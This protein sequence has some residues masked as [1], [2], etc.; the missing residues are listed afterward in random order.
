MLVR[1]YK[2]QRAFI[3]KEAKRMQVSQAQVV[4]HYIDGYRLTEPLATQ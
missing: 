3:R 1:F 2:D 4:R